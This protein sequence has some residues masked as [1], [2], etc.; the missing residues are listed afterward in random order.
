MDQLLTRLVE[1]CILGVAESGWEVGGSDAAR[2]VCFHL[3]RRYFSD[4]AS[5]YINTAPDHV[6]SIAEATFELVV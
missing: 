6:A 2:M 3:I 5:G 4:I 1:S